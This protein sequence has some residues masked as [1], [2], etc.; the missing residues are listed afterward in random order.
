M[1]DIDN[2]ALRS[3]RSGFMLPDRK[4]VVMRR[5]LG[6][7]GASAMTIALSGGTAF[8]INPPATGGGDNGGGT[9][10]T[11]PPGTTQ[12]YISFGKANAYGLEINPSM[13]SASLNFDM[14]P[15]PV[16]TQIRFISQAGDGSIS[17]DTDWIDLSDGGTI[18]RGPGP[19]SVT[20]NTP[21]N[22]NSLDISGGTLFE[23]QFTDGQG[24]VSFAEGE[25]YPPDPTTGQC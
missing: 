15:N 23:A 9:G 11:T 22:N 19:G 5:L 2:A 17:K 13:L 1:F 12:C 4:G 10:A 24:N 18:W 8:A 20:Y 25:T 14:G 3:G 6:I 16:K 7:V 21:D